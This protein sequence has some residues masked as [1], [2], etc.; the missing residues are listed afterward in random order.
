[1]SDFEGFEPANTVPVPD[2]LFDLLLSELKEAELK[3]LLYIIRRTT[4]FKKTTDAI[5]L[6]QFQRGIVTRDKKRLDHGCGVKDRTT[7][8]QALE[9]LEK[10]KCIERVKSKTASGD[11][12]T[13][14]YRIYFKEVVGNSDYGSGQNLPPVVGDPYHGSGQNLPGVVGIPDSQETVIQGTEFQETDSQESTPLSAL[15]T[16]DLLAEL[17]RRDALPTESK[18]AKPTR[19][20][21]PKEEQP[22]PEPPQMPA[23]SM[24]WS[25][26]KCMLL[27]DA[28]R[29]ATLIGRYK[30]KEAEDC[31]KGLAEQ[32]TEEQ[33]RAV[34]KSMNELDYWQAR[35][36]AD[37]CN[38]ANNISKEIKKIR[39]V[40]E[41]TQP[42]DIQIYWNTT[43]KKKC[44]DPDQWRWM[45]MSEAVSFGYTPEL[46]LSD[47]EIRDTET[48]RLMKRENEARKLEQETAHG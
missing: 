2:I 20:R 8:V 40:E 30:I 44:M 25:T 28:W 38:V 39:P 17:R 34:Y 7:I 10:K 27:F 46:K 14:R 48:R 23:A 47:R 42:D 36:G 6:S 37:I 41:T 9:S 31:A 29:G 19:K 18:P 32:Y 11:K 24:P 1:M 3:C 43:G 5:S 45:S 4:G 33:V 16:E 15:S 12:D 13:T 22:K 21:P 35:G 26:Q